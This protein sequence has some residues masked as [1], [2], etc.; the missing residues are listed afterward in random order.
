VKVD[1]HHLR[2]PRPLPVLSVLVSIGLLTQPDPAVFAR[3]GALLAL[4]GVLW[5]LSRRPDLTQR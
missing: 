4:G 5:L 1:H 3:A 2:V